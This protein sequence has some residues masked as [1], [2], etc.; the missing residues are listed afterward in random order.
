VWWAHTYVACPW[1]TWI[2]SSFSRYHC[3]PAGNDDLVETRMADCSEEWLDNAP[4]IWALMALFQGLLIMDNENPAARLILL[5]PR[6]HLCTH[7]S[8]GRARSM[9]AKTCL[10][11]LSF[12]PAPLLTPEQCHFP[13]ILLYIGNPG[14]NGALGL[15]ETPCP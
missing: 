8:F 9:V 3:S 12:G 6:E 4:F 15:H 2:P 5:N 11:Y 14:K 13:S 1:I 10:A 7:Q